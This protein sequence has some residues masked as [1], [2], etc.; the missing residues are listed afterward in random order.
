MPATTD[1]S[2]SATPGT[3]TVMEQKLPLSVRFSDTS[4]IHPSCEDEVPCVEKQSGSSKQPDSATVIG[5]PHSGRRNRRNN[6]A[7]RLRE[8][9]LAEE[10]ARHQARKVQQNIEKVKE[11]SQQL[12]PSALA[13][14]VKQ[15]VAN[16]LKELGIRQPLPGVP[17][18]G[19]APVFPVSYCDGCIETIA[20]YFENE[21]MAGKVV[22]AE[23]MSEGEGKVFIED[24]DRKKLATL[25]LLSLRLHFYDH[26]TVQAFN[27]R[28]MEQGGALYGV[29]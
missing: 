29:P 15:Y 25:F 24:K 13:S 23:E 28:A 9:Q 5:K 20:S 27:S 22:N 10:K 8:Q 4:E 11:F 3:L 18:N 6:S 26:V 21:N 17:I 1:S 7:A 16:D 19:Q 14:F 12:T 2:V